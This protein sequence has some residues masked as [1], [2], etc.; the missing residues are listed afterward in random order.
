MTPEKIA[1]PIPFLKSNSAMAALSTGSPFFAPA[2]ATV[3]MPATV[4]RRP[5]RMMLPDGL[6]I[7]LS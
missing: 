7:R 6:P 4:T 1:T 2:R 5:T 3:T